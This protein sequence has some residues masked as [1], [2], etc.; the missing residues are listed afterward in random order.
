MK[1]ETISK[2]VKASG[3]TAGELILIHFWG[4]DEDREIAHRFVTAVAE[5]GAS[6]L[7]LQQSRRRN[8]E[9][10]SRA[11]ESCFDESYFALFSRFNAV[12]DVFVYQPVVLG[13]E[14]APEAMARYRRYM[15]QLFEQLMQCRR[16]TQIRLPTPA[17]AAQARLAPEDFVRR[18]ERAYDLDYEGV[19]TACRQEIRRWDG[20]E[21][22]ELRSGEDCLLRF[23]VAGRRWH[24]DAGDGD[25]PCGE[26]YLAPL[27]EQTEGCVFFDTLWLEGT[28]YEGVVLQVHCGE[29]CSSSHPE[30]AAHFARRPR[31][32]RI[33]CE[34]G[35]G[36]NPGVTDLCGY[37]VLD[38]KMAGS[39]HIAVG[40]NEMFGGANKASDHV[41]FVGHGE[42]S[43]IE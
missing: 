31:E 15:G 29:V 11:G 8:Q 36:M 18:M 32:E 10:F 27:E 41:D 14:I 43:V 12:L 17:N 3:V 35:L 19:E 33:V 6:P 38:E 21:R 7:L 13:G 39:F 20:A 42:L 25:L 4:E 1:Q 2:L 23:A 24:I 16:F 26:I 5:Q 40:D 22:L 34:L 28:H 37:T 9:L 30:V